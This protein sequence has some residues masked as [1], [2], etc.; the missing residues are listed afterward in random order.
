[1]LKGD[2]MSLASL[3]EVAQKISRH[4]QYVPLDTFGGFHRRAVPLKG[5]LDVLLPGGSKGH[6]VH[7]IPIGLHRAYSACK[8]PKAP[9]EPRI[10]RDPAPTGA[11][12]IL[13]SPKGQAE[14]QIP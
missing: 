4:K 1:M 10:L 12:G 11:F 8:A 2:F 13:K 9:G 6:R 14:Q 3:R 7:V 5:Q